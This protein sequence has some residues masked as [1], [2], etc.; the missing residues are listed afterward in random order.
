VWKSIPTSKT[1]KL[2]MQNSTSDPT[3]VLLA[4]DDDDDY[5]LF[6]LAIAEVPFKV[7]LTRAED[8]EKLMRLLDEKTPDILFLDIMMPCKTGHECLREIRANRKYDKLPIIIYSSLDDLKNIEL[9][10]R[11]GS[12]LYAIKPTSYHD[13]KDILE[14]V[15]SVD[16]KKVLYFPT[17]SQ[18]VLRTQ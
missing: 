2:H 5:F 7:L 12:N 16:W 15:L 3:H 18:Y 11:E 14:R 13:L 4:E 6:S 9:C 17:L 8:G 1:Y 10:Y